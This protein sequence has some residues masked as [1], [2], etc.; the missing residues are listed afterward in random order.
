MGGEV[1]KGRWRKRRDNVGDVN[2]EEE[3]R[4]NG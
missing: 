2:G 3:E 1:R 4:S